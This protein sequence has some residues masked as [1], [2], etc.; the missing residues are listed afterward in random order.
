MWS[1]RTRYDT[2]KDFDS[3]NWFGFAREYPSSDVVVSTNKGTEGSR[4]GRS[5]KV[6]WTC[7]RTEEGDLVFDGLVPDPCE[8]VKRRV[9]DRVV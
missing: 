4:V 7:V 8:S 5:V 2:D 9:V 6:Q 1:F 3:R